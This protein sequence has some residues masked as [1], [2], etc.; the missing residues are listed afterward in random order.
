MPVVPI[1]L[2]LCALGLYLSLLM[3]RK[4]LRAARGALAEASVVHSPRAR[5]FGGI[6]NAAVGMAFYPL[7]AF[8]TLAP[9]FPA[10]EIA[11]TLGIL[12]ACATSLYLIYSLLF[13][14][15]RPCLL[16]Y[17]AHA[18]NFALLFAWFEYV[19]G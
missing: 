18:V 8:G 11:V 17:G 5:L 9:P 6:S 13:V 4:A 19:R 7:V 10:T 1:I 15:R 3:Y 2:T 16:C 14:T 12:A